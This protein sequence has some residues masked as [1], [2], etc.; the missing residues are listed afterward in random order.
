MKIKGNFKKTFF[1]SDKGY[2]VGLFKVK[3][4]TDDL[5]KEYVGKSITFSGYLPPLNETDYYLLDG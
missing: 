2:Q 4:V 5:Y 1:K 3:D